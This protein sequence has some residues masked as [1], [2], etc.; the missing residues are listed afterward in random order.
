MKKAIG[1]SVVAAL[2]VGYT[3]LATYAISTQGIEQLLICADHGGLKVPFSKQ[4]C[5]EYLFGFRGSQEDID[6]L[7]HGI[8]AL[9][10]VQGQSTMAERSELLKFLVGKGLDVNRAGMRQPPPL[11]GAVL[12]NSADE[13]KILLDLGGSPSLRDNSL[14]LTPLEL[15]LK[16]QSED[17]SPSDRN[18]VIALLRDAQPS[19]PPDTDH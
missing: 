19:G 13:V 2:L 15:A 9:F 5:R 7:Q 8:G 4:I 14:G 1:A 18:A 16:L 17:K 6:T 12:A 10:V 11:H 3:G